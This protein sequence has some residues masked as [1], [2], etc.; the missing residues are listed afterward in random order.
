M[1][2]QISRYEEKAM[3]AIKIKGLFG[4]FDYDI[5]LANEGITILTGPNGYGKS[6]IIRCIYAL[7]NSD[8]EYFQELDFSSLEIIMEN[9][10]ENLLIEKQDDVLIFNKKISIGRENTRLWK[11]GIRHRGE[12][13]PIEKRFFEEQERAESIYANYKCVLENL[14]KN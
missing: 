7:R 3:I 1:T 4:C 13:E 2:E 8:I 12:F 9:S 11:K 6:T 5:E 14:K 10:R